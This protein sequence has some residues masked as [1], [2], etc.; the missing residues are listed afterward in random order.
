MRRR[1]FIRAFGGAAAVWPLVAYGQEAPQPPL[2]AV[3]SPLFSDAAAPNIEALREGFRDLGYIEGKNFVLELR[4]GNG[5]HELMAREA[6][7]LVSLKPAVILTGSEA[8]ILAVHNA[9]STIP[10]VMTGV[11]R[12]PVALGLVKSIRRPGGNITGTWIYGDG[13]LFGKRLELLKDA[14]PGATHIGVLVNPGDPTE[15]KLLPPAAEQL[16]VVLHIIEVREAADLATAFPA[17]SR[18]GAQA[19]FVSQS[20]L[21]NSHRTEEAAAVVG[22]RLPAVYGFRQFAEAGGLMSYGT[23]L[24]D[25]YRR[26]AALVDKILHGTSPADLPIEIPTRYELVLNEKAAEAIGFTFPPMLL[27]R[28][29]EVLE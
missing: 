22:E 17:A 14:V 5:M 3:L 8:G 16:G 9:I 4:Y 10:I 21:F 28:A 13:A 7:E 11:I 24:P 1:E 29:D 20:P 18:A 15:D 23:S 6:A 27:A 12:D 26:S 2:V 25:V 19:L